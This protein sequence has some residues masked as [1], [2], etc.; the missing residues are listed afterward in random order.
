MAIVYILID[1]YHVT[2]GGAIGGSIV[3]VSLGHR[4]S[5]ELFVL[6]E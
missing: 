4:R 3:V 2:L 1:V 5:D 6:F